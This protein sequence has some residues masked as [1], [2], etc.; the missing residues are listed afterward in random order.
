MSEEMV[1]RVTLKEKVQ[2]VLN[3]RDVKMRPG[4]MQAVVKD[5]LT[6]SY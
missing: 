6:K 3:S 1:R 5:N 4:L 2:R